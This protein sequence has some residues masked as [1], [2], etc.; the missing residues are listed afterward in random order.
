M[1]KSWS[2]KNIRTL[3]MI[4]EESCFGFVYFSVS[5]LRVKIKKLDDITIISLGLP[6]DSFVLIAKMYGYSI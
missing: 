3:G 4:V 1:Q 5:F 6:H 2:D